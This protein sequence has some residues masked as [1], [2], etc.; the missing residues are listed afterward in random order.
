MV[1]GRHMEQPDTMKGKGL[2]Q[3]VQWIIFQESV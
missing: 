2:N 1:K 3:A